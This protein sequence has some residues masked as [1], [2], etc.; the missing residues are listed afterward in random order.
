MVELTEASQ[1]RK[2]MV[3]ADCDHPSEVIAGTKKDYGYSDDGPYAGAVIVR[4]EDAVF[5][6]LTGDGRSDAV[7]PMWCTAGGVSWPE[8][9]LV[10]GLGVRLLG[11]VPVG[12]LDAPQEHADVQSLEL[13]D[14]EVAVRFTSYEGAGSSA[15]NYRGTLRWED[16]EPI[17]DYGDGPLTVSYEGEPSGFGIGSGVVK[18]SDDAETWLGPAPQDFRDFVQGEWEDLGGDPGC[19]ATVTVDRYSHLGFASGNL[20]SCGGYMALW[21]KDGGGWQEVFGYQEGPYCTRMSD[22]AQEAITALGIECLPSSEAVQGVLLGTEWPA[23][24]E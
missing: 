21:A 18:E 5:G 23:S 12:D 14:S 19:P 8:R 15:A 1:L 17:F 7:V 22:R 16:S 3:P 6:D 2:L 4:V 11:S 20:G 13:S 10:Y 24:G 9:L